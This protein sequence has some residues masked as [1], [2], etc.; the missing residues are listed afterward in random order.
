MW[1][2]FGGPR[3]QLHDAERCTLRAV[4]VFDAMAAA[5]LVQMLT[6]QLPGL[7]IEQT[8]VQTVPLDTDHATDPARWRAVICRLNLDTSIQMHGSFAVLVIAKRFQR[9]GQQRWFFFG[10]HGGHLPLG[11]AVNALISPAF[12][13]AIEVCLCSLKAL[14]SLPFQRCLLGMSN[15]GFHLAF[16][17]RIAHATG[18]RDGAIVC[19]HVAIEWIDAGVV[20]VWREYAFLQVVEHYDSGRSTQTTEGLLMQF[21]PD[22]PAGMEAEK[23]D[24]LAAE[25]ERQHKKTSAPVLARLR[26]ADHGTAAIID[27]S[28]LTWRGLDDG[29]RFGRLRS[30][31]L[32]DV[33]FDAFI[34]AGEAVLVYQFLPDRHGVPAT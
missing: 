14:E 10:K 28:L 25:A 20:D 16:A 30:A 24:A 8:N 9:Q 11:A 3:Q 15:A 17:I 19:Q 13:P 29:A 32:A 23:P 7:R 12:F 2:G 22:A 34:G 27:L 18:H 6:Q 4:F 1:P 31:Q 26:I 33:A 21:G 5:L